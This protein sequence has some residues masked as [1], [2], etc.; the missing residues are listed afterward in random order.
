MI[1][2]NPY[3]KSNVNVAQGPRTGN[4]SPRAG[5]RATFLDAKAERQPIADEIESAFAKREQDDYAD[6]DFP[7]EGSI[8]ENNPMRHF[9]KRRSR[10][11][12]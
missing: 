6:H 2:K 5:K 8:S 1:T 12:D 11:Q 9:A 10:Y 7:K 4:S 3:S